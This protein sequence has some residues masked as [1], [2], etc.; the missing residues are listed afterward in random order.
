MIY[1]TDLGS[2]LKVHEL[3]DY[4]PKR[5]SKDEIVKEFHKYVSLYDRDCKE[6]FKVES[7][8]IEDSIRY[9]CVKYLTTNHFAVLPEPLN[10]DFEFI[11]DRNNLRKT[12]IINNGVYYYGSEIRYWFFIHKIDLCSPKYKAFKKYVEPYSCNS[13]S[14]TSIYTVVGNLNENDIYTVCKFVKQQERR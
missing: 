9:Y 1:P 8:F 4:I 14:D 12:D 2:L 3:Y 6:P 10:V 13:I 7:S 5:F 11:K